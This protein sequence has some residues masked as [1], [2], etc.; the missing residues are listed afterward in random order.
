MNYRELADECADETAA[1]RATS[2]VGAPSPFPVRHPRT[3]FR[4]RLSRVITFE[5]FLSERSGTL[6]QR[7]ERTVGLL[8]DWH[9]EII[10]HWTHGAPGWAPS[11]ATEV[12][13]RSRLD[14]QASLCACLRLWLDV[15]PDQSDGRLILAWVNLGTLVE[16]T[17]KFFLSVFAH[18]YGKT[19]KLRKKKALDPD[20]LSFEELR[21]FFRA[22]VWSAGQEFWDA[23]LS[24][25]QRR[26]NA[27]HAYRH[28]EIGTHDEYLCA[29][30]GYWKLARELNDQIPW[31]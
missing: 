25:V 27:V 15:R 29:I 17:L 18:D 28:T 1:R 16:G 26:R 13:S 4:R 9:A 22:R 2:P 12:L 11:V 20:E 8:E 7:A 6:R 14:R 31:Q 19:P 24:S 30:A 23:W 21:V 5:E 10:R 3:A